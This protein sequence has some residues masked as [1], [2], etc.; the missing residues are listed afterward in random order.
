MTYPIMKALKRGFH[1]KRCHFWML[2]F[3]HGVNSLKQMFYNMIVFIQTLTFTAIK[4]NIMANTT[5]I[6]KPCNKG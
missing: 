3:N 1:Y 6:A 2:I 5:V 4:F